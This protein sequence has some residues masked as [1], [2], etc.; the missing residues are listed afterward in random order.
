MPRITAELPRELSDFALSCAVAKHYGNLDRVI[1]N[2]LRL[3]RQREERRHEL[4]ASL[5]AAMVE[6]EREGWVSF[7]NVKKVSAFARAALRG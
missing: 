7:W 1:C 6:S 4:L 5:N 2:A 3:L